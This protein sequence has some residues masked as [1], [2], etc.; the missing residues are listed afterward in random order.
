MD[1]GNIVTPNLGWG[2]FS[3]FHKRHPRQQS[4]ATVIEPGL[5]AMAIPMAS[6]SEPARP[7]QAGCIEPQRRVQMKID[8]ALRVSGAFVCNPQSDNRARRA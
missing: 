6:A 8:A 2:D 1:R 7:T 4:L 3:V 5:G